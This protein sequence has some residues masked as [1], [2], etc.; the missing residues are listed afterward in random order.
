MSVRAYRPAPG[1]ELR[2]LVEL[3]LSDPDALAAMPER[4]R[5]RAWRDEL[6]VRFRDGAAF[7]YVPMADS[8]NVPIPQGLYW[9]DVCG[10]GAAFG[11]QFLLPEA[12][13][14]MNA[15]L[16]ARACMKAF[17]K[18]FPGVGLV[19]GL[20]PSA[21]RAAVAVAVR[22]G[23]R[24]RGPVRADGVPCRLLAGERLELL[25]GG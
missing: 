2:A 1:P 6:F 14:G 23:L 15:V 17:L 4:Q 8:E 20:T 24:D 16:C 9:V 21:N 22:A 7:A 5:C 18:D 12:R 13:R 11:H 3:V 19:F 25:K 10:A